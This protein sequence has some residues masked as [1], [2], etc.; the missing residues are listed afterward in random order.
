[1]QVTGI[2]GRLAALSAQFTAPR[3]WRE[4]PRHLPRLP[5]RDPGSP[6][7]T[8]RA[9]V[10]ASS[11]LLLH[12]IHTPG[13]APD[14][15]IAMNPAALITNYR[16]LKPGGLVIVNTDKFGEAR[17]GRRPT[18]RPTRSTTA[19]STA[20]ASSRS[21]SPSSPRRPSRPS[22]SSAK[23]SD[24]CK[25]FFAWASSIGSTP[26]HRATQTGSARSSRPYLEANLAALQAGWSYAETLEL[27][28][29]T[30]EVPARPLPPGTYRNIT[31][32]EALALGPR[33]RRREPRRSAVLGSYPITPASDIL[34]DPGEVQNFG[35][36]TFQAE[37][38]IAAVCSAIGASYGGAI[39]VTT[40]SGPGLA[41]KERGLGLAVMTELPLVVVDVQ[42]GG[43]STGLPTKTEQA[44]LLQAMY[45]RNGEAP[46]RARGR[47]PAT[48][49]WSPSRPSASPSSTWS[50]SSS[51]PTAT[52]PTA[53]SPGP[54]RRRRAQPTSPSPSAPTPRD[55]SP[56]S[57]T[58]SP[59]RALGGP[60]TPGLEHRI[61]GSRSRTSPAT[62]ATTR[63]TTSTWSTCAP[64]RSAASQDAI[65]PTEV[66]GDADGLLVVGWGWHLRQPS[67]PPWSSALRGPQGRPP[68]PAAP[69]PLPQGP[70]R[71]A[72]AASG[73]RGRARAQPRPARAESC[74]PS[75]WSTPQAGSQGQ[76]SPFESQADL[77]EARSHGAPCRRGA[78]VMT[79]PR[80]TEER[81]HVR[82]AH[83][84]VPRLWRLQH[85]QPRSRPF[86]PSSASPVRTSRLE[87]GHRLLQPL[88]LLHEHLRLSHHPRPRAGGGDGPQGR[89]A[90]PRRVAGHRRRRRALHRRQPLHPPAAPQ[91][92][93]QAPAVQQPDLR[94]HQGPV[95]PDL[96]EGKKTKST[97]MGSVDRPFDPLRFRA[98]RRGHL[99]GPERSTC[100]PP[101]CARC[102]TRPTTTSG[103]SFVEI[104]QN[105]NI[106]NDGAFAGFTDKSV[107]DERSSTSPWRAARLGDR[108]P[109][110][111]RP[112]G[113]RLEVVV[114]GEGLTDQDC[115]VHDVRTATSPGCLANM[116]PDA[117]FPV[118]IG[119]FYQHQPRDLRPRRPRPDRPGPRRRRD[120]R[121]PEGP[122]LG[123]H[124]DRRADRYRP[125]PQPLARGLS[126]P[127]RRLL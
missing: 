30:Y 40:T 24:R 69:Q 77:V 98:R 43:P 14:V 76:A 28:Q 111:P 86:S 67:A 80:R 84:L 4:R 94:P 3:R 116:D 15:L 47:T 103:T 102:C 33:R 70:R 88:P 17:P 118:A 109:S 75:S 99:R 82:P 96:G 53:P 41:L 65:P 20:S 48:A 123:R 59:S 108:R 1:M 97:P 36:I 78:T 16:A 63:R 19:P 71:A 51:S 73:S 124:M 27:F 121:P 74:A 106:F 68:A 12:D 11:P 29:T 23:E 101:T 50:P 64:R 89:P 58:P 46:S 34:H 93:P 13:D 95:L 107:R 66:H 120:R 45:G 21:P 91:R 31:G 100:S 9:G 105:C 57:A 38:E 5:R 8:S 92:R 42:R 6:A 44:D 113:L 114:L 125:H 18:C 32:N 117:G 104:F 35:V 55:S 56:T 61:G 127:P 81:L 72:L 52:S 10:S 2:P 22:A 90:R 112:Q 7:G 60:G 83:P 126:P 25:N 119:L 26:R 39:G 54:A 85:P 62:S 122:E 115:L 79:A 37:D 110:G 87:S 49:S